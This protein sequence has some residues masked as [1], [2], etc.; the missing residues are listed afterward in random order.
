MSDLYTSQIRIRNKL[1]EVRKGAYRDIY[2]YTKLS[3]VASMEA[4]SLVLIATS[5]GM[6]TND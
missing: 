5:L 3:S 6:V 1:P 4:L 2:E